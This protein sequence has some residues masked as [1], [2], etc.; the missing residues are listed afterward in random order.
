MNDFTMR[1]DTFEKNIDFYYAIIYL[2]TTE[3]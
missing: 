2:K 1:N 3:K